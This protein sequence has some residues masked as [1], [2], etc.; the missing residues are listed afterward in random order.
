[1]SFAIVPRE[2]SLPPATD[3]RS[4]NEW[5]FGLAALLAAGIAVVLMWRSPSSRAVPAEVRS[6]V[7]AIAALDRDFEKG[8]LPEETYREKRRSLKREVRETLSNP[9]L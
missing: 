9:D 5:I 4:S 7:E 6:Q 8:R 2:A 3:Q 1:L